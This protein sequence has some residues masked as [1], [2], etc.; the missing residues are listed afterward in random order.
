[1]FQ[2]LAASGHQKLLRTV[3]RS[4]FQPASI[5]FV[6]A[7]T[8]QNQHKHIIGWV[9]VIVGI[10]HFLDP[11]PYE[12]LY[13]PP[14]V[15]VM[16]LRFSPQLDFQKSWSEK[17]WSIAL[18]ST[19]HYLFLID[20]CKMQP[21]QKLKWNAKKEL[22]KYRRCRGS[23]SGHPRDRREYSPLY[24]NDLVER[25]APIN[26]FMGLSKRNQPKKETQPW[27]PT[28]ATNISQAP[29]QK[30]NTSIACI[31][32]TKTHGNVIYKKKTRQASTKFSAD[33]QL[34]VSATRY[35]L[36][37]RRQIPHHLLERGKTTIPCHLNKNL[38]PCLPPVSYALVTKDQS[39][40]AAKISN[41]VTE[42]D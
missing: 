18:W 40:L 14:Y 22:K 1:L 20:I 27:T 31:D 35:M 30:K 12:Q 19:L 42:G 7:K 25:I 9:V 33:I 13:L 34:S 41:G 26:L 15:I 21:P 17:S 23:N 24:Y 3:K 37:R 10:Y 16:I 8:I 32:Q 38:R 39:L 2:L 4:A 29:D 28:V 11:E 6:G 36:H 5:K